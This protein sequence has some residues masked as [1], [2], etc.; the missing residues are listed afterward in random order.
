MKRSVT[1]FL[2]LIFAVCMAEVASSVT[3]T[4]V[5][6]AFKGYPIG[7]KRSGPKPGLRYGEDISSGRQRLF[8]GYVDVSGKKKKYMK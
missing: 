3:S 2:T 6:R 4:R 7:G 8:P 1:V 5:K